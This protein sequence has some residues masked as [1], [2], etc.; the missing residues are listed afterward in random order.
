[1][2]TEDPNTQLSV[3]APSFIIQEEFDRYSGYWWQPSSGKDGVYRILYEEV[4]VS[5]GCG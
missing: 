3:G 5:S 4:G 1:M 2:I